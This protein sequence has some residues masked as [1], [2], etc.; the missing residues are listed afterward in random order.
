V[1]GWAGDTKR[2]AGMG[3]VAWF[4]KEAGG[5]EE[6]MHACMHGGHVGFVWHWVGKASEEGIDRLI[7]CRGLVGRE[8]FL[9]CMYY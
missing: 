1:L 2:H 6:G 8:F 3:V 9:L 4:R 5:G 7:G